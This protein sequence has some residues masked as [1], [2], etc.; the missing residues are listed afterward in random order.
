VLNALPTTIYYNVD[1]VRNGR[2]YSTR[3]VRAVQ[4]GKIIFIMLCSFQKPEPWQPTYRSPMPKVPS[5]EECETLPAYFRKRAEEQTDDW[6]KRYYLVRAKVGI[7]IHPFR[8]LTETSRL[9]SSERSPI[10]VRI[11]AEDFQDGYYVQCYW[12]RAISLPECDA[13]YQK[14]GVSSSSLAL[15]PLTVSSLGRPC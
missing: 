4:N 6:T 15:L 10:G 5:P 1:H 11:A 8:S 7:L 12:M 9:K 2:S 3:A 14:V 13:A